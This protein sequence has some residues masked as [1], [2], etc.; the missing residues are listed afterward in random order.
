MIE[1]LWLKVQKGVVYSQGMYTWWC[2][3]YT[4]LVLQV[5]KRGLWYTASSLVY[6]FSLKCTCAHNIAYKYS[7]HVVCIVQYQ[8]Y[9]NYCSKFSLIIK[10]DILL[11]FYVKCK[12][13]VLYI[14]PK[15]RSVSIHIQQ[16][17]AGG[18]KHLTVR[19]TLCV[20][21]TAWRTYGTCSTAQTVDS[22]SCR[23]RPPT[24]NKT[25]LKFEKCIHH[26]TTTIDL[27]II[28]LVLKSVLL[29]LTTAHCVSTVI[30][31]IIVLLTCTSMWF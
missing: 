2:K 18:R 10:C 8:F 1:K 17:S 11:K 20:P 14:F 22:W 31:N 26:W 27:N 29:M 25:Y 16:H 30:F 7:L 21:D 19:W 15:S 3:L 9:T 5:K 4:W 12:R 13:N 28:C 6:L 24:T 23:I